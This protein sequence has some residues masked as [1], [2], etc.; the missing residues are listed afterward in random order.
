MAVL[1]AGML[2]RTSSGAMYQTEA[3]TTA[4]R[5]M[6]SC[7]D[8]HTPGSPWQ[9]TGSAGMKGK[10]QEREP[11]Y[12]MGLRLAV[13]ALLVEAALGLEVRWDSTRR[14]GV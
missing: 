8:F 2:P 1:A 3:P 11:T 10:W 13:M 6:L 4:Q 12:H 9:E 5:P 7:R 14:H